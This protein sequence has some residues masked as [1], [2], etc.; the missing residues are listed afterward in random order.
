MHTNKCP[1]QQ[2][3]QFLHILASIKYNQFPSASIDA[4]QRPIFDTGTGTWNVHYAGQLV[5]SCNDCTVTKQP[6]HFCHEP[7][8][9]R[10]VA[11]SKTKKGEGGY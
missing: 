9:K 1:F 7:R 8:C 3:A 11:K 4:N 10:E 6:S 2:I 5:L